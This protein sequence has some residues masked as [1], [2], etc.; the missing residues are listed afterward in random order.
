M[1]M[2]PE[3]SRCDGT[4]LVEAGCCPCPSCGGQGYFIGKPK[5]CMAP[6]DEDDPSSFCDYP[7]CYCG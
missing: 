5:F 3:C 4:G 6:E 2:D 1:D 7:N